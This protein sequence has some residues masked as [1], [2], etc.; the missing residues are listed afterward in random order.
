MVDPY[1]RRVTKRI[2]RKGAARMGLTRASCPRSCGPPPAAASKIAPGDF[3][4][5]LARLLCCVPNPPSGSL[6]P[7]C[8][9]RIDL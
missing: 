6:E 9:L 2:A 4:A 3:V 7:P 5:P 1:Q 8:G